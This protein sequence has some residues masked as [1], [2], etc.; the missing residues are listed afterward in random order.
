MEKNPVEVKAFFIQIYGALF[1]YNII[2]DGV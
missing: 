2:A 1:L